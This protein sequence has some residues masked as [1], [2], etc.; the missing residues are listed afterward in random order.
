MSK[1][2][3]VSVL[4]AMVLALSLFSATVF[5]TG[6][7]P[8]GYAGFDWGKMVTNVYT[9]QVQWSD[10]HWD[11]CYWGDVR[12]KSLNFTLYGFHSASSQGWQK[13][14]LV[15]PGLEYWA[16]QTWYEKVTVNVPELVSENVVLQ[17]PHNLPACYEHMGT[18]YDAA[19]KTFFVMC[20]LK[21]P[22]TWAVKPAVTAPAAAAPAAA[23]AKA[24]VPLVP[25]AGF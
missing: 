20:A 17:G 12:P 22:A 7:T 21:D 15:S 23:P 4:V 16:N 5:A 24:C 13:P 6:G 19:S 25:V 1:K 2:R 10:I 3:M 9:V 14:L 11:T 18:T 8:S